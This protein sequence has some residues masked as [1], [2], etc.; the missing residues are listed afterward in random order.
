VPPSLRAQQLNADGNAA[1]DAGRLDDAIAAFSQAAALA[2]SWSTPWYNLGLVY[3]RQKQ[4]RQSLEHNRRAA[5]LDPSNEPAWWN[6]GI[7]ATATGDWDLARAAWRGFGIDVP[8]GD[9]PIDLPCGVGPIR[10]E[11]DGDGE[12][13]WC[14]RLDPARAQILSIPLPESGHCWQDVVLNDG[15]PVG[16]RQYRGQER[17]VFNAL[18][19]LE[20]SP[21]GTYVARVAMPKDRASIT[22][23]SEIAAECGGA[24][25][26]WSASVR[27][28][29]KACSEGR[30]HERHDTELPADGA[31]LIGIAARSREHASEILQA[32]EAGREDVRVEWLDDA[33]VRG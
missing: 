15:E 2:P 22:R 10:L 33:L 29:C 31:H 4:W 26:D 21:F 24:A 12:V 17:P 7:A 25:E 1:L 28:I 16:Y 3:K 27:M 19:L 6:M 30:P 23:L 11:P 9:G 20:R 5:A 8:D 32:F 13:V 18:A 14:Q